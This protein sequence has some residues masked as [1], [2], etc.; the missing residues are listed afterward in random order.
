MAA[1]TPQRR[2]DGAFRPPRGGAAGKLN[3]RAG[4]PQIRGLSANIGQN[5]KILYEDEM[6]KE[7]NK[8][9]LYSVTEQTLTT[10]NFL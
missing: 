5:N 8:R 10:T 6:R 1:F 9:H 7:S 4:E 3:Q 2:K